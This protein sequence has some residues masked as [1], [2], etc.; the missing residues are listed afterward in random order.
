[1]HSNT[2]R[3]KASAFAGCSCRRRSVKIA[4]IISL[5]THT[6]CPIMV[7]R[8]RTLGGNRHHLGLLTKTLY[9]STPPPLPTRSSGGRRSE[10]FLLYDFALCIRDSI[11][12]SARQTLLLMFR[13]ESK[14]DWLANGSVI[15]C[16]SSGGSSVD[17]KARHW[18]RKC[19]LAYLHVTSLF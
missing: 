3:L 10:R 18:R 1:M 12:R 5:F 19:N 7:G 4:G 15:P 14:C 13:E 9:M 8:R 2:R 16:S 11:S 17:T 6:P